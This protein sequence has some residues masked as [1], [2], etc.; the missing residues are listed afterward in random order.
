MSNAFDLTVKALR[1]Q[2]LNSDEILEELS[3]LFQQLEDS[4]KKADPDESTEARIR[5]LLKDVGMPAHIKGYDYWTVAIQLYKK[6]GK[7]NI[8]VG[9]IYRSVAKMCGSTQN[10]VE[11]V[12]KFAV[13]RVLDRCSQETMKTLFGDNIERYKGEF[14]NLE[15][16]AV[17]AELI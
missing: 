16:L 9:E 3:R 17:M 11:R 10:S 14:T 13:E 7:G 12:M 5:K 6:R 4:N 1:E 15:F 2:G 8:K